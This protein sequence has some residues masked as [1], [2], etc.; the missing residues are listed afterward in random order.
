MWDSPA[1]GISTYS[2]WVEG[3]GSG[4]KKRKRGRETQV[5]G[6][7]ARLSASIMLM[8]TAGA[9]QDVSWHYSPPGANERGA[10]EG[11]LNS[12][13]FFP[14]V[15][16]KSRVVCVCVCRER[17]GGGGGFGR[18]GWVSRTK[19]E[20]MSNT[21]SLCMWEL[22]V[23]WGIFS[24]VFQRVCFPSQCVAQGLSCIS[25]SSTPLWRHTHTHV[26]ALSCLC[27]NG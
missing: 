16:G 12:A 6:P 25:Q 27:F 20:Q 24:F 14:A 13:F 15:W 3:E 11:F 5:V 18:E 22:L 9:P 19:G 2:E 21:N 4:V 23:P 8:W 7:H 26:K 17:G 10:G 1:A